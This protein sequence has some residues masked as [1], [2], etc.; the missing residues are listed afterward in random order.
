MRCVVCERDG[1]EAK[2]VKCANPSCPN[3]V[4]E[5]HK[6]R[7]EIASDVDM[8]VEDYCS[9]ACYIQH[10]RRSLPVWKELMIAFTVIVIAA[11][12]YLSVVSRFL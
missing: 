4:C 9:R 8:S 10:V 11:V 3:Y 7:Y 6:L 1:H 2:L 5:Y 12:L